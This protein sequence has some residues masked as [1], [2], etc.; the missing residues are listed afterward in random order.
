M[1]EVIQD[2]D[3]AFFGWASTE[4]QYAE[5]SSD[6]TQSSSTFLRDHDLDYWSNLESFLPV[7][8]IKYFISL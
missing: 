4:L 1:G 7:A 8:D 2:R 5:N 3:G 6:Q